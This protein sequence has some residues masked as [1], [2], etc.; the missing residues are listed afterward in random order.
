MSY[1]PPLLPRPIGTY[2]QAW[3]LTTT[4]DPRPPAC[5]LWKRG[6][7]CTAAPRRCAQPPPFPPPPAREGKPIFPPPLAGEGRGRDAGGGRRRRAGRVG[8]AGGRS[9]P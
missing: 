5:A 7:P 6:S 8:R 1:K 9:P 2:Q 3:R 4:E